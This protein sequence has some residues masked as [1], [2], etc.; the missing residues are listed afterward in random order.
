MC[1]D[2][3]RDDFAGGGCLKERGGLVTRMWPGWKK[4]ITPGSEMVSMDAEDRGA[5]ER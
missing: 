4:G 5:R 3:I 2:A 1:S